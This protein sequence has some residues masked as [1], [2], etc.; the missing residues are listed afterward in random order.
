MPK[1]LVEDAFGKSTL[2]M[3]KVEIFDWIGFL[4]E[5]NSIVISFLN[6]MA[7]I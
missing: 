3:Y 5:R 7:D 2:L 1:N 6:S 4:L